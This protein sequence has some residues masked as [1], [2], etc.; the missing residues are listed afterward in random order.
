[1]GYSRRE[2]RYARENFDR[3]LHTTL[4]PEGP[5]V[6]R[7]HLIPP[8]I[9]DGELSNSV[10]I[11]NGQDILPVN[12]AWSVVLSEFI[13]ELEPYDGREISD[14]A[15]KKI[16]AATVK[17]VHKVYP[18]VSRKRITGDL[19]RMLQTF[20]QVAYRE[21]VEEEIGM[22][23]L[24]EYAP[25]LRAPHRMDLCVSAMTKDGAWHCNQKCVHC[26]AA[27]QELAEQKE[28]STAEWMK[29]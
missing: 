2:R 19:Y 3:V 7:I 9:N 22:L 8:K 24:G 20:R 18:F 1:M 25:F 14:E 15:M 13:K 17:R 10:A 6:V 5:G 12:M 23:S 21:R 28:L 4:N 16:G 11:I 27:G 26:Y 29:I